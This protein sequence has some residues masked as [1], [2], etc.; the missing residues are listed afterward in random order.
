[1]GFDF[2]NVDKVGHSSTHPLVD[3]RTTNTRGATQSAS[4]S[5]TAAQPHGE[6]RK[7]RATHSPL[8]ALSL[9]SG[10]QPNVSAYS[11]SQDT[12]IASPQSATNLVPESNTRSISSTTST[13]PPTASWQNLSPELIGQIALWLPQTADLVSLCHVDRTTHA[14]VGRLLA[15]D[16]LVKESATVTQGTAFAD[17]LN[18]IDALG[19]ELREKPLA[20]L[21]DRIEFL[22]LAE[23]AEAFIRNLEQAQEIPRQICAAPLMRLSFQ[24]AGLP[25]V[26]RKG[27]LDQIFTTIESA[28]RENKITAQDYAKTLSGLAYSLSSL[29]DS[30]KEEVAMR[31]LAAIGQLPA[32]NQALPI[33]SLGY[34]IGALASPLCDAVFDDAWIKTEQ[35]GPRYHSKALAGL[36]S[37]VHSLSEPEQRQLAFQQIFAASVALPKHYHGQILGNLSAQVAYLPEL[38]RKTAFDQVWS[39][40]SPSHG[41]HYEDVVQRLATAVATLTLEARTCDFDKIHTAASCLDDTARAIA[42]IRLSEAVPYLRQQDRLLRLANLFRDV[43]QI[44]QAHRQQAFVALMLPFQ[45][46]SYDEKTAIY[47][48]FFP[49]GGPA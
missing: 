20:M 29:L 36:S 41:K 3:T 6:A 42:L 48:T 4:A 2:V 35:I 31:L 39:A 28:Y 12:P 15:R 45:S 9:N 10:G 43:Q 19:G 5:F 37:A 21:A 33:E 44:S 16:K 8:A 40:I 7:N 18:R 22:P 38:E 1:M 25:E 17:M 13:A 34:R 24:I 30:D 23:R 27:A 14:E 49:Q 47:T 32:K 46:L 11:T 26:N